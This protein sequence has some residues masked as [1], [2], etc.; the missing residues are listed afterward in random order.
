[1]VLN[2]GKVLNQRYEIIGK[3]GSG[4]MSDVYKAKDLKLNRQ[5]A[6]KVLKQEFSTDQNFVAKFRMEA[7]SAACLSHPN[8]VNIFDVGEEASVYFIVMELIEGITL[9][10]YIERRKKLG[11]RETIEV[12]MQV[13]R[14]LEAAHAEH[15]IHRDIKPQNIMISK[16]GKIKVTDFGIA[17]AASFQTI[18]SNTMGSVHYISP[19]QA[20]GGYCDERSDLYSLGVTMYEMLTGKLP[21]EGDSTVAIALAHIQNEMVPPRE[22]EPMIPISLEKIILK[23]TQ[24]KPE[25]RYSSAG[26]L[27]EDL[28]KALTNPNEDFVKIF[29]VAPAGE[30]RVFG[31]EEKN[32]IQRE[33]ERFEKER[34]EEQRY[35]MGVDDEEEPP[36]EHDE[37]EDDDTDSHF[38]KIIAYLG[39]G[40][41]V[42]IAVILIIIGIKSCNLFDFSGDPETTA[43]ETETTESETAAPIEMPRLLG[44]SY[45]EAQQE[46]E[47]MGLHIKASYES[48][49]EYSEGQIFEQSVPE[50]DMVEPG[51]VIEVKVSTGETVVQIPGGLSGRTP[52]EATGVLQ[53]AGFTNVSPTYTEE[54]SDTVPAGHVIRTNPAEGTAVP[55]SAAITLIVSTGKA[56]TTVNVPDV[57]GLPI[58]EARSLIAAKNL[59]VGTIDETYSSSFSIGE[60]VNQ[61]PEA[62]TPVTE[63]TAMTLVISLGTETVEVPDLRGDTLSEAKNELES[64]G[65]HLGDDSYESSDEGS[66]NRVISQSIKGGKEVQKGTYIDIIIGTGPEETEPPTT[67]PSTS[68]TQPSET[69]S[70]GLEDI[71]D[72]AVEGN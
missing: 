51:T 4:G 57:R 55:K 22:F 16:E 43:V 32:Q 59:T 8:I 20:K 41:G 38:E 34:L 7:Q 53:G 35:Q 5:V 47:E 69:P 26:E 9:K 17:R 66:K 58:E 21:Y 6:V 60:V 56:V 30:T 14:G 68:E 31:A 1:M 12:A 10:K 71:D 64:V 29:P 37:D 3:I 65:L 2:V 39:I 67:E 33:T 45:D 61:S 50:G 44:R 13:A 72:P 25:M 52:E 15:I 70:N 63:G 24:K 49:D 46:L 54:A 62:G 23:C 18:S 28:K 27:I 48:S 40:I 19:E 42:L 36:A 11:I